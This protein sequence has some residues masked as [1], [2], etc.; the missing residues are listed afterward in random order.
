MLSA[1]RKRAA[2]LCRTSPA[3]SELLEAHLLVGRTDNHNNLA[4]LLAGVLAEHDAGGA[5]PALLRRLQMDGNVFVPE[6]SR[7]FSLGGSV[8]YGARGGQLYFKPQGWLRYA[9]HVDGFE[10]YKG[11]CVAYHGTTSQNMASILL[12]GLRRPGEP[13]VQVVHG[14]AGS[15]TNRTIYVSPSIEY[16]AFPTY[17][18][19]VPL[20]R[21]EHWGQLVLQCRVRPGSFTERAGTLGG[22][23]WPQHVR[24]DPNF[25]SLGGLEWL[26]E[27]PEDVV[28]YGLM[29]RE[30]GPS[31]E[32]YGELAK[33]VRRRS[34][35]GPEFQ[36]T[37]LRAEEFERRGLLLRAM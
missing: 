15:T 29:V 10:R 6:F 14:Q 25:D 24:F 33:K 8:D 34:D 30:F 37:Q 27:N 36:W 23:Y 12:R 9:L 4:K 5:L 17:A 3:P 35:L 11:W 19:L 22:K 20:E 7:A 16:A 13:G 2:V 31:V 26:L 28:V 18:Q 1:A 21:D 32:G